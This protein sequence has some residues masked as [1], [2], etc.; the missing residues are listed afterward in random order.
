MLVL[1]LHL[2]EKL[3]TVFPRLGGVGIV[4]H[5]G[6]SLKRIV[7]IMAKFTHGVHRLGEIFVVFILHFFQL[8]RL[9]ERHFQLGFLLVV[10]D[11]LDE[12]AV[13]QHPRRADVDNYVQHFYSFA[14]LAQADKKKPAY[15]HLHREDS[16]KLPQFGIHLDL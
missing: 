13:G 8:H 3:P 9:V 14:I 2:L 11:S 16:E 15:D 7:H 4:H 6:Q 1:F 5:N 10:I 12:K